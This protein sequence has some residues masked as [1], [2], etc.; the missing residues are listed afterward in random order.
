[1]GRNTRRVSLLAPALCRLAAAPAPAPAPAASAA[2]KKVLALYFSMRQ[3]P[4]LMDVDT[5][6]RRALADGLG[7]RLEYSTENIDLSR[8]SDPA[9]D[10]AVPAYPRAKDDENPAGVRLT[11]AS[12]HLPVCRRDPLVSD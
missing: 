7:D 12:S 3:A 6:L 11:T 5:T 10:T 2:R 1:M 9:Y 4:I 8:L